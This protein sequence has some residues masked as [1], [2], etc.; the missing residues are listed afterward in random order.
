MAQTLGEH[1]DGAA[2]SIVTTP[3]PN[4]SQ[5]NELLGVDC[6]DTSNCWAVGHTG[7]PSG[8][9]DLTLA[10]QWNGTGWSVVPSP[11]PSASQP[12]IFEGVFCNTTSDCWAVGGPAPGR[13]GYSSFGDILT[14]HW[15]GSAWSVFQTPNPGR[16]NQLF[17]IACNNTSDCW[18][19]GY[20]VG[21][22][23]KP[24]T[25]HGTL[26]AASVP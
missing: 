12:N 10:E 24:L 18:A 7:S 5:V 25:E 20:S 21:R 11:S 23:Q 4:P 22:L 19:A 1:W 6:V 15:D 26:S 8:N 13:D 3:N 16:T 17:G 14:E 9:P 2:W